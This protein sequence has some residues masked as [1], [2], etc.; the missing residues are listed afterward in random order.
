[1][2]TKEIHHRATHAEQTEKCCADKCTDKCK[3]SKC[4]L[5]AI[6]VFACI[7]ALVAAIFSILAF[8]TA[9]KSTPANL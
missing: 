5:C 2:I 8:V 7:F 1:M 3:G 9:K 6:C 4:G